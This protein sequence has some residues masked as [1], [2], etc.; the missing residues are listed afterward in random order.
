LE[1]EK[2]LRRFDC[3]LDTLELFEDDAD[4]ETK[5]AASSLLLHIQTMKFVTFLVFFGRLYEFSEFCTKAL[6]SPKTN[7]ATCIGL[8]NEFTVRLQQFDYHQVVAYASELSNKFGI[9]NFDV[10]VTRQ[11][12]MPSAF[13]SSHVLSTTGQNRSCDTDELTAQLHQVLGQ[14]SSEIRHRFADDQIGIM[15]TAA[16][17]LPSVTIP[18]TSCTVERLF[19]SVKRIKTRIRSRMTTSRLN[20]LGLLSFEKDLTCSLNYDDIL[21]AF[22]TM[23]ARRLFF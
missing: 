21:L 9:T 1:V 11:R 3:I 18:Q 15:S 2:V 23:K 12:R 7:V 13:K 20:S 14:I 19:S 17:C 22:R 8:I 10:R 6:Q 5:L 4:A 16:C